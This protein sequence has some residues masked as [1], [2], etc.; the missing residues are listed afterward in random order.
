MSHLNAH[1]MTSTNTGGAYG[2]NAAL[3]SSLCGP[4][5]TSVCDVHTRI[6]VYKYPWPQV[7]TPRTSASPSRV[8]GQVVEFIDIY[9]TLAA[10]AGLPPPDDLDGQDLS[11]IIIGTETDSPRGPTSS[12]PTHDIAHTNSGS[13]SAGGV[14]IESG[15]EITDEPAAF[16]QITRCWKSYVS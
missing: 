11:G 1:N 4:F 15:S 3:H 7:R 2:L 9:P 13:M 6:C 5:F 8:V 10:L 16:S 14:G 12:A